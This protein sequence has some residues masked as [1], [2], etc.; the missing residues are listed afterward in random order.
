[1]R[2]LALADGLAVRGWQCTFGCNATAAD[3]AP[4]LARHLVGIAD[5]SGH[6]PLHNGD[7][8]WDLAVVDHY[9]LD[10]AYES[11]LRAHCERIMVIDDLHNRSHDCDVLLDQTPGRQIADYQPLVPGHCRLLLGSAYAL[12]RPEFAIARTAASDARGEARG[13]RRIFV[14]FGATDPFNLTRKALEG[15]ALS[16]VDADVDVVLGQ[17][18]PHLDDVRERAER[19]P[20]RATV[21]VAPNNF[22]SLMATADIAFGAPGSMSWERCCLGIPSVVVAFAANQVEIAGALERVGA[23]I[24]LGWHEAVGSRQF[25][26]VLVGLA[27]DTK[28]L[29]R[30]AT[31]AVKVS[32]GRGVQRVVE[33]L[34]P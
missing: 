29:I 18:A 24:H 19:L 33:V 21:H 5:D 17:A 1:M 28:T 9:G 31:A 10:G 6:P 25:A 15:I 27:G 8:Q 12:L 11:C 20:V 32:D 16:G 2:C 13:V 34:A 4:G 22:V 7:L 26:E 3:V 30:M 23:A 14:A